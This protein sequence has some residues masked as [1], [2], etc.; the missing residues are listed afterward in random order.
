A[1]FF[2]SPTT[3]VLTTG[4]IPITDDLTITGLGQSLI[5]VDG[6]ALSQIFN[7]NIP[8]TAG[9]VSISGLTITNGNATSD[10]GAIFNQNENL[11]V[12]ASTISDS[13]T[14]T[15]GGG[16]G[17]GANGSLTL[18][19]ST[20]SGNSGGTGGGVYFLANGSLAVSGSTISG[21]KSAVYGGGVYF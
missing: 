11:T 9:T 13:T 3:I 1:G 15:Q 8:G 5:T 18:V 17:I 12:T 4:V 10:G 7:I 6:N 19:N 20:V 16:I 2:T 21:N 14:S